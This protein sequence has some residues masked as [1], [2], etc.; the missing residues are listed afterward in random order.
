MLCVSGEN[1]SGTPGNKQA[2]WRTDPSKAGAGGCIGD[3]GSHAFNLADFIRPFKVISLSIVDNVNIKP[4][5]TSS[6]KSTSMEEFFNLSPDPNVNPSFLQLNE[7]GKVLGAL[8]E[9]SH[10]GDASLSQLILISD[11]K[12]SFN[13]SLVGT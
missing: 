13:S 4:L 3:I 11:S 1:A 6:N 10:S 2:L 9:I 5:F 12:R 8:A 7:S